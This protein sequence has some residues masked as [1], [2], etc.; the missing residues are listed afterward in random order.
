[1][2]LDQVRQVATDMETAQ[3]LERRADR[4]ANPALAALLRERA[5]DRRRRA[6]RLRADLVRHE[7]ALRWLPS[8]VLVP[9]ATGRAD[10]GVRR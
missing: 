5:L 6:A 4:S 3:C 10:R 1:V 8:S 9:A 7:N 2:L